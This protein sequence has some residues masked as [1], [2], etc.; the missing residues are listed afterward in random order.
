MIKIIED[1]YIVSLKKNTDITINYEDTEVNLPIQ[2]KEEIKNV[3]A[4][5]GD[6]FT[7]GEIFF[8]KN[9]DINNT[10]NKVFLDVCNSHYDHYVYT[11]TK[12]TFDEYSCLNLW[13]GAIIETKDN[14]LVLGKM[15]GSTIAEGEYHISGGSTDIDDVEFQEIDHRR[16]M[17]RE[18][19]EEFGLKIDDDIVKDSYLRAIKVPNRKEQEFSFGILYKVEL[20]ITFEEFEKRFNKYLEHLK[21][22]KLE[23]EFTE[24]LGIDKTEE[25]IKEAEKKYGDR[26]PKYTIELFLK[27][28]E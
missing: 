11:R 6:R 19:Y 23:I 27:E 22:N 14:K 26:I 15:S 3:W 17:A 28:L 8:I 1:E 20:D 7:N 21:T 13:S 25:A 5:K 9:Y 10:T 2:I 18:V 16:T 24:M 4:E 12:N